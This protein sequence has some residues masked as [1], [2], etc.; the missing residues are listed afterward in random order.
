MNRPD[1]DDFSADAAL[2]D[3]LGRARPVA[4]SPFFARRVRRAVIDEPRTVDG[5]IVLLRRLWMPASVVGALALL[6]LVHAPFS[7]AGL[8][9]GGESEFELIADL[10][11]VAMNTESTLWL[12]PSSSR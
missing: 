4:V 11:L 9:A 10:D 5:W 6:A 8:L 2:W 12:A 1:P 3:A 7:G